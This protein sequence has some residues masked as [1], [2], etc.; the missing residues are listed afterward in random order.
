VLRRKT[1][2][3]LGGAE[4]IVRTHLDDTLKAL[5]PKERETAARVFRFLV[6]PSGTK[7][8][9]TGPDLADYAELPA[10]NV[11]Q[12]LEKLASAEI[13]ILRPVAPPPDQPPTLRYEI[14]HDV[15]APS[16][17]DW[18]GR[19]LEEVARTKQQQ[20]REQERIVGAVRG[21]SWPVCGRVAAAGIC[22]TVPFIVAILSGPDANVTA[23]KWLILAGS[24]G[25]LVALVAAGRRISDAWHGILRGVTLNVNHRHLA[26]LFV[27]RWGDTSALIGRRGSYSKIDPTACVRIRQLRMAVA[28]AA[29]LAALLPLVMP[30]AIIA[31]GSRDLIPVSV[32]PFAFGGPPALLFAMI[33]GGLR[34]ELALRRKSL[35]PESAESRNANE[36]DDISWADGLGEFASAGAAKRLKNLRRVRWVATVAV[37]LALVTC[38]VT[39]I[40]FVWVAFRVDDVWAGTAGVAARYARSAQHTRELDLG[41]PY[42]LRVDSSITLDDA[43]EALRQVVEANWDSPLWRDNVRALILRSRDPGFSYSDSVVLDGLSRRPAFTAYSVLARSPQV[44]MLPSG[45]AFDS[46][47]YGQTRSADLAQVERAAFLLAAGGSDNARLAEIALREIIS[48]AL[49]RADNLT[50]DGELIFGPT[51]SVRLGLEELRNLYLV[52]DSTQAVAD[53][54]R[55]LDSLYSDPE[56]IRPGLLGGAERPAKAVTPRTSLMEM[57]RDS[58]L[59]RYYRYGA[60][61]D[62]LLVSPC[63]NLR[64]LI[65]GLET[66]VENTIDAARQAFAKNRDESDRFDAYFRRY[67]FS[68][69]DRADGPLAW[70]PDLDFDR[71]DFGWRKP[72][73]MLAAVLLAGRNTHCLEDFVE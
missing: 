4:R 39:A 2:V 40:P 62:L 63:T 6:T 60:L 58:D 61:A 15:L 65:F 1:L 51:R 54:A 22:L 42:R 30:F 21:A 23:M 10:S 18:R 69:L 73:G 55:T 16:I 13:R 44:V 32:A 72:A 36:R 11:T 47:S 25:G 24:L 59:Q 19:Y 52:L 43:N 20:K 49:L 35:S 67:G 71:V 3:R 26:E 28:A 53:L 50:I 31:G 33:L 68:S 8:A 27:D 17:I 48:V 70:A 46:W 56:D 5:P 57:V 45:R 37:I 66:D 34:W 9:H 29:V 7:I 38:A 12:V 64:E 41:R 14:Y